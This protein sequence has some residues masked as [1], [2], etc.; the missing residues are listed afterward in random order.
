V[1]SAVSLPPLGTLMHQPLKDQLLGAWLGHRSPLLLSEGYGAGSLHRRAM[2]L[3]AARLRTDTAA[4]SA[5]KRDG[6]ISP[7]APTAMRRSR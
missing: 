5:M 3:S 1:V 2:I 4:W 6:W 7:E